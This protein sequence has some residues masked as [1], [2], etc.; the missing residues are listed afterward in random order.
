MLRRLWCIILGSHLRK[1]VM[2]NT[3]DRG[4]TIILEPRCFR[5]GKELPE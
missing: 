1:P 2:E 3:I 5:C 4:Y